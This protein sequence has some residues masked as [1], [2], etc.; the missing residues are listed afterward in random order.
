[1][2][3]N[4]WA[5]YTT[6]NSVGLNLQ[7]PLAIGYFIDATDFFIPFCSNTAVSQFLK[8]SVGN[9]Y[10]GDEREECNCNY[11][12]FFFFVSAKRELHL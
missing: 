1:M 6:L 7:I 2:A 12:R 3:V 10:R 5:N 11:G 4:L 8:C 9:N